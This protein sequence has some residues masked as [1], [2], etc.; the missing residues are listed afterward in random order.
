M[1][2]RVPVIFYIIW[3]VGFWRVLI[4]VCEI[5]E[6]FLSAFV[7]K[8]A[9]G[10]VNA[11]ML[12]D[13]FLFPKKTLYLDFIIPVPAI[14]LVGVFFFYANSAHFFFSGKRIIFDNQS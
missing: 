14:L 8:G 4:I 11:I 12:L 3:T 2:I 1:H 7:V 6:F 5:Y 13:I 9:S 10:A